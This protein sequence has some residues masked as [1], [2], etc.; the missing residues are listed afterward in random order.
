[1]SLFDAGAYRKSEKVRY[2]VVGLGWI[3]QEVILPGFKGA[4]NSEL[5]ALITDDPEK[6]R[7]LS[8]K[9]DVTETLDY[10][11]YDSFLRTGKVDAVYITLPN[12][13]HKDYTVRAAQAGIHV[14]CEKPM[15]NNVAECEEMIRAAEQN[16]IKL[17]IAYRLHFEPANLKA[18]EI[19]QSG[20][21]GDLRIFSSVFSQQVP[22]DNVRLK[23]SAGGGPLMDMGVYPINASRYLFREEPIEVTAV[24]ANSGDP[25]FTEVHE[26]LAAIL[27]FPADKLAILTCSFGAAPA[28]AYQVVGTKGE[29][30]LQPAFDYHEKPKLKMKI[31]D[32]DKETKFDTV[33]QFGGEIEYFSRCILENRE[34]EPSGQEGLADLR[35][36]EALLQSARSSQTV[37]LGPFEKRT[38]PSEEQKMEKPAVKPETDLVNAKSASGQ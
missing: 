20:E 31:G 12:H 34:P 22:E 23:K 6:A 3:A 18:V 26:M 25:R 24:G 2:A 36:V 32:K 11:A 17:M 30:W 27:R 33:D 1:M 21:L 9:Y 16:N 14:L 28:D 19:A 4:K 10:D 37:K 15:A 35:I 5:V 38:R 8:K 29:L 13:L 7:E